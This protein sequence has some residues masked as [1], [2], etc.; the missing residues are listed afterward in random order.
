[1][2]P[3][4]E[5]KLVSDFPSLF[6]DYNGKPSETCMC[7]GMS[8]SDGWH[9]IF[10]E[11]CVKLME[12]VNKLPEDERKDIYFLQVKEKF[13]A[14]RVYISCATPEIDAL[15]DEYE[16]KSCTVC[17]QCGKPGKIVGNGWSYAACPEHTRS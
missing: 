12:L 8:F 11:L 5:L 16:T 10:R 9:D 2:S 3:D 7:Y 4:L 6:R 1:M 14:M 15:I 13:G 17:E